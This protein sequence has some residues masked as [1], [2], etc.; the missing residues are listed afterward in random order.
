MVPLPLFSN[1]YRPL[2][3]LILV[4]AS[5]NNSTALQHKIQNNTTKRKME[6]SMAGTFY[7]DTVKEA[8]GEN[9]QGQLLKVISNEKF[10]NDQTCLL[11]IRKIKNN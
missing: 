2:K 7:K 9:R 10:S 6:M 11:N 5:F 3:D 4:D 1:I 8:E